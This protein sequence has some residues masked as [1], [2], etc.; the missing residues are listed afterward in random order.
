[1]V[2]QAEEAIEKRARKA[3]KAR[4]REDLMAST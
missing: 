2:A 4:S 1:M 3:R